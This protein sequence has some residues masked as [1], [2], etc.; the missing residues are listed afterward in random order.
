MSNKWEC[1]VRK[2]WFKLRMSCPHSSHQSGCLKLNFWTYSNQITSLLWI[3]KHS[4]SR[5]LS[6]HLT[7]WIRLSGRIVLWLVR[8]RR[9]LLGMLSQEDL[10]AKDYP[11]RWVPLSHLKAE[12]LNFIS[13]RIRF[14]WPK[15]KKALIWKKNQHSGSLLI[16]LF[17]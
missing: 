12:V 1:W 17:K 8:F 10:L 3:F 15:L 9:T 11:L 16:V 5:S 2:T 13:L 14:F 7:L 6:C 4:S